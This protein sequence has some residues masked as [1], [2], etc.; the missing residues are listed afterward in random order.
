MMAIHPQY[1]N[2]N[3]GKKMVVLLKKEFNTLMELLD[4]IEDVEI[5]DQAKKEY[6]GKRIELNNYLKKR[7]DKNALVHYSFNQKSRKTN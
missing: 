2:D 6:K 1:I 4:D 5:Y 7:K 3:N